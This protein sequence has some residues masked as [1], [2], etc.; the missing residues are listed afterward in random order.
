MSMTYHP[1]HLT[2]LGLTTLPN[3]AP[4]TLRSPARTACLAPCAKGSR[5]SAVTTGT[6][7]E[8]FGH[9]PP[10]A[11]GGGIGVKIT[12]PIV[13]KVMF[14]PHEEL[15]ICR[16][17]LCIHRDGSAFILLQI[18]PSCLVFVPPTPIPKW[19]ALH[20]APLSPDVHSPCPNPPCTLLL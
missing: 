6:G 13:I 11:R 16:I 20:C 19:P 4:P 8:L 12:P 18:T 7:L 10:S 17:F 14:R 2:P 9:M 1:S 5:P 3:Q 15:K